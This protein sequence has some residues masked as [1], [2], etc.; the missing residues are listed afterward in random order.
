MTRCGLLVKDFLHLGAHALNCPV[1]VC[2]G[3]IE[4]KLSSIGRHT[5]RL[6][7]GGKVCGRL[8]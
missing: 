6:C 5:A 8:S 4:T 2:D 3:H 7:Q 1:I